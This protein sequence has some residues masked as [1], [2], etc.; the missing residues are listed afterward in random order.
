MTPDKNFRLGDALLERILDTVV[1]IDRNVQDILDRMSD[2][3]DDV[4]YQ[5]NWDNAD[6]GERHDY[7]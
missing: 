5:T 6:L 4:K 7:E 1:S 2:H 3:L